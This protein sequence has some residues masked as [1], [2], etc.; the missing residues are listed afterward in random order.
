MGILR[1]EET[2]VTHVL[3]VRHAQAF[4][5][6]GGGD[7]DGSRASAVLTETGQLQA[8]DIAARLS[9]L[10]LRRL[11]SSPHQ[12][13]L[14]TAG[15]IARVQRIDVEVRGE[16][17]EQ[18]RGPLLSATKSTDIEHLFPAEWRGWQSGD[19]EY[20]PPGGEST[21]AFLSRVEAFLREAANEPGPIVA[22]T[23]FGFIQGAVC[24][25]LGVPFRFRLPLDIGEASITHL[26]LTN[27]ERVLVT[28]ND[29]SHCK[30][31]PEQIR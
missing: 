11:L 6:E 22:V 1:L 26:H 16:L 28:F 17:A 24:T 18:D 30:T 13:A 7:E 10:A 19:P 29:L 23:H 8:R 5:S 9:G 21:G 4:P 27:G 25:A 15:C 12:R 2:L 20:A 3:L 31:L 14:E